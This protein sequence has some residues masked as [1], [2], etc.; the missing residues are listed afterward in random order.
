M[1]YFPRARRKRAKGTTGPARPRR[2]ARRNPGTKAGAAKRI[3]NMKHKAKLA[4]ASKRVAAAK[5]RKGPVGIQ[6]DMVQAWKSAQGSAAKRR[7]KK[8]SAAFKVRGRMLIT[9]AKKGR[10]K[11]SKKVWRMELR[12][13]PRVTAQMRDALR[14]ASA[15]ATQAVSTTNKAAEKMPAGP[16]KVA[17]RTSAAGIEAVNEGLKKLGLRVDQIDGK[18]TK[19]AGAF[20]ASRARLARIEMFVSHKRGGA[21]GLKAA[22]GRIQKRL[23]A[24]ARGEYAHNLEEAMERSQ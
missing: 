7:G 4:A 1:I 9:S 22:G 12:S 19:L 11:K 14:A 2:K 3:A 5:K 24:V 23:S 13:N 18:V 15:S 21:K 16:A 6:W 20:D 10:G 8:G 17:A